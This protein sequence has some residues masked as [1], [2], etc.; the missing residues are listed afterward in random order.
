MNL[1]HFSSPTHLFKNTQAR[2]NDYVDLEFKKD[3]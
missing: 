3:E 2:I 1:R